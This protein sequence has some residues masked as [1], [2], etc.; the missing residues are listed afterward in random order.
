MRLRA[1]L[2]VGGRNL[3]IGVL[4][5]CLTAAGVG[6]QARAPR[7]VLTASRDTPV[8]TTRSPGAEGIRFGFEGGRVVKV[9][10]IYHLFTS[11]MVDDPIWVRM[12]LGHWTSADREHWTRVATIRE[13]SGEFAGADPRAALWSPL[14]V[15][16]DGEERW[17]LFYVAYRSKPGEGT[18]FTLNYEG[19][20]WRARSTVPGESGISGPYEDV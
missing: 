16:D 14:P 9:A 4:L 17:N 20:I 18:A 2:D 19:R 7:L 5:A 8:I 13:S 1:G 6:G 15:W 3:A 11:E 10:G 12:R